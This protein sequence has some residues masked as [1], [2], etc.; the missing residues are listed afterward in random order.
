VFKRVFF[1][2]ICLTI[3]CGQIIAQL[4]QQQL[5]E[6]A[7]EGNIQQVQMLLDQKIPVDFKD[8]ETG[9][10]ALMAAALGG[11]TEL[12][13]FLIGKKANVNAGDKDNSTP[14]MAAVAAKNPAVVELLINAKANVNATD[15]MGD[16]ALIFAAAGGQTE[17]VRRLIAA[18]AN[19]N[20]KDSFGETALLLA[21]EEAHNDIVSMLVEAKANV[22]AADIDGTTALMLAVMDNNIELVKFLIEA[23]A[24]VNA[25]NSA[26]V[27]PLM[28]AALFGHTEI[29]KI[30]IDS[31]ANVNAV[32]SQNITALVFAAMMD[33]T[34]AAKLLL[35]AGAKVDVKTKGLELPETSKIAKA[36]SGPGA[37][38]KILMGVG[39]LLNV[40]GG[41]AQGGLD[42]MLI[43]GLV[44]LF[45]GGKKKAPADV[46]YTALMIAAKNGNDVLVESLLAYKANVNLTSNLNTNALY[47]AAEE[48]NSS[49]VKLLLAAGANVKARHKISGDTTLIVG[50]VSGDL[51]TVRLLLAAG[52]NVKDSDSIGITPLMRAAEQSNALFKAVLDGGGAETVNKTSKD[53]SSALMFAAYADKADNAKM[54]IDA[55][56][57]VKLKTKFD[58]TALLLAADSG[59]IS[60]VSM[61]MAAGADPDVKTKNGITP[62]SAALSAGAYKLRE[63]WYKGRVFPLD[64]EMLFETEKPVSTALLNPLYTAKTNVNGKDSNGHTLLMLAA[65]TSHTEIVN[66]LL[67]AKADVKAKSKA[68]Q[69]ALMFAVLRNNAEIVN[70]LIAAKANPNDKDPDGVT[71]LMVAAGMGNAKIANDLI[72]ARADIKA[73]SKSGDSAL[74]FAAYGG[75]AE[76]VDSLITLKANV[77]EK[78]KEGITPLMFAAASGNA[79]AVNSLLEA[80]ADVKPKNSEGAT[81]LMFSANHQVTD[82]LLKAGADLKGRFNPSFI[83]TFFLPFT[84]NSS[85]ITPLMVAAQRGDA[86]SFDLL[87]KAGADINEKSRGGLN[88][89]AFAAS[90]GN[91]KLFDLCMNAK[92]PLDSGTL[93]AALTPGSGPFIQKPG[94]IVKIKNLVQFVSENEEMHK[95][96]KEPDARIVRK[97]LA[98]GI[99]VNG[100]PPP[101]YYA[102]AFS[103]V[104]LFKS[105]IT[106]G[107]N[108]N[109]RRKMEPIVNAVQHS[110]PDLVK[111]LLEAKAN[112]K[113]AVKVLEKW[114]EYGISLSKEQRE[115][116]T[117]LLTHIQIGKGKGKYPHPHSPLRNGLLEGVL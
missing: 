37:G 39:G 71:V 114:M 100:N 117:M 107:A 73:K 111:V 51:E 96:F 116:Y 29:V 92:L 65:A 76:V 113:P 2:G 21:A 78:N 62:F 20:A 70:H 12:V 90:G 105:L 22:N 75:S 3:F 53:N 80:G 4:P 17:I 84:M 59:D 41:V 83:N 33:K 31:K 106:A 14:L 57:N 7:E 25:A 24:N 101:L 110:R 6:A 74:G 81:A 15:K 85:N 112:P 63:G 102:A 56:V 1:I 66:R 19:V 27:T 72:T 32:E 35:E 91:E 34:A 5:L 28:F 46:G 58:E 87:V 40:A 26:K 82:L 49:T 11:H 18:K 47:G 23:K 50:V 108:V 86:E 98:A 67:E 88:M 48:G 55:G 109:G 60:L 8:P 9:H 77:N 64:M 104:D 61:L 89:L 38:T 97:L 54:L 95:K 94:T 69:T 68:G 30:L 93:A 52:A 13:S 43:G 44:G 103:S 10:T 36:L 42:S 79:K 16:T 99:P 115:I 45:G